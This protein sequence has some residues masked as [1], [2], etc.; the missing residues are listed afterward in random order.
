[1][2]KNPGAPLRCRVCK[3]PFYHY[4]LRLAHM[5]DEHERKSA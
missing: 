2:K 5:R 3:A 4:T 1:M